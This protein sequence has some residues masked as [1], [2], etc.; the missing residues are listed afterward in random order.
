MNN[1]SSS[2]PNS[3]IFQIIKEK[4]K[5]IYEQFKRVSKKIGE[6]ISTDSCSQTTENVSK[7]TE[8]TK[9][10]IIK[11]EEKESHKEN[12][13]KE[14]KICNELS[15][16]G[17]LNEYA[18]YKPIFEVLHDIKERYVKVIKI[19]LINGNEY[20]LKT[21][22]LENN[23]KNKIFRIDKE[24]FLL[25]YCSAL[26]DNVVKTYDYRKKD[27]NE[28]EKD[29]ISIEIL[30]EYG[31]KSLSKCL[32]ELT[33]Q[34]IIL[35]IMQLV[36]VFCIM[37][38][39]GI[40][41]LDLK[42]NN[43]VYNDKTK[44]IKLIDFGA[45]SY[46]FHSPKGVL[47]CL[48]NDVGKFHEYS[49]EYAPPEVLLTPKSETYK[50]IIPQKYDIFSFGITC[51]EL[52]LSECKVKMPAS[53]SYANQSVYNLITLL[54]E[55]VPKDAKNNEKLIMEVIVKCLNYEA[56]KRPEFKKVKDEFK[57]LFERKEFQSYLTQS[58]NNEHKIASQCEE[59]K[60]YTEH[61][62][63]E[64]KI[65]D[66][67][68]KK[69]FSIIESKSIKADF[70]KQNSD[71]KHLLDIIYMKQ[72]AGKSALQVADCCQNL[73]D[74][75]Y[76]NNNFPLAVECYK[77]SKNIFNKEKGKNDLSNIVVSAKIASVYDLLGMKEVSLNI[78]NE[79][80]EI[81]YKMNE[82]KYS[83]IKKDFTDFKVSSDQF[84][85]Y[86]M[87]L[88]LC[89]KDINY[90]VKLFEV[91][92]LS[93]AITCINNCRLYID[94]NNAKA[95]NYLLDSL[96]LFKD[97]PAFAKKAIGVFFAA[98]PLYYN[99][100]NYKNR[101]CFIKGM[102]FYENAM[103]IIK[104]EFTEDNSLKL[105]WEFNL[106]SIY[107]ELERYEESLQFYLSALFLFKVS[108]P[109]GHPAI[110]T[111]NSAIIENYAKIASI[112]NQKN[113]FELREINLDKKANNNS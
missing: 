64:L 37:E 63:E 32:N 52:L 104:E 13:E 27:F 19:T 55:K 33:I 59:V 16:T 112:T 20:V 74:I 75:L 10:T 8:N 92:K 106:A 51:A 1:S 79:T 11:E 60:G 111:L 88:N 99:Y 38:E 87:A 76:N 77:V 42:P 80:L 105:S 85:K 6:N 45:G 54:Q 29:K 7:I 30:Q 21:L 34:D 17:I 69:A 2:N 58:N 24:I 89:V 28:D 44:Q 108:F 101:S 84:G 9:E 26:S 18:K 86:E 36:N 41:H 50:K 94:I 25:E 113:N 109:I 110:P 56:E 4:S 98:L 82:D 68:N 62:Y 15:K 67:L 61:H 5:E 95:M 78:I 70:E 14:I 39:N 53:F 72:I 48:G 46:F 12:L 43:I 31:G 57:E 100:N 65:N 22:H 83:S 73:G 81:C 71:I 103:K 35:I 66:N 107:F 40:C 90:I 3:K 97:F 23:N 91:E 96:H 93:C 49:K 102:Q 47:S